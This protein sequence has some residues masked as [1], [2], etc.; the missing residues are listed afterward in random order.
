M[1]KQKLNRL[2]HINLYKKYWVPG[3]LLSLIFKLYNVKIKS[4]YAFYFLSY[5]LHSNILHKKII[6]MLCP[7]NLRSKPPT[8]RPKAKDIM[9]QFFNTVTSLYLHHSMIVDKVDAFPKKYLKVVLRGDQVWYF[10]WT[11]STLFF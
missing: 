3:S 10:K 6:R 2:I 5:C 8:N 7:K 11:A 1:K 4:N 9:V